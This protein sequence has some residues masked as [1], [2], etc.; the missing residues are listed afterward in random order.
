M[1]GQERNLEGEAKGKA[2]HRSAAA[3]SRTALRSRW[4]K[5]ANRA[6]RQSGVEPSRKPYRDANDVPHS[7]LHRGGVQGRGP[8]ASEALA[9]RT[10]HQLRGGRYKDEDEIA[11]WEPALRRQ[12]LQRRIGG[13]ASANYGGSKSPTLTHRGWGTR[14]AKGNDRSECATRRYCAGLPKLRRRPVLRI[15]SLRCVPAGGLLR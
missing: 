9:L 11:G 10:R 8:V 14:K 6:E 5:R 4:A 7:K 2:Q 13:S 1:E 15:T 3:W 12:R